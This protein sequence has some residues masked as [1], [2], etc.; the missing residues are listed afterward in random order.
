MGSA[1]SCGLRTVLRVNTAESAPLHAHAALASVSLHTDTRAGCSLSWRFQ[2]VWGSSQSCSCRPVPGAL[3]G[4]GL[5]ARSTN[6]SPHRDTEG[7]RDS[8]AA[9]CHSCALG[10]C[11]TR[12]LRP[13]ALPELHSEVLIRQRSVLHAIPSGCAAERVQSG[14]T[15]QVRSEHEVGGSTT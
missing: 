13:T 9:S 15:C 10:M 2:G 8:P 14:R 7:R 6:L 11:V 3:P 1:L 5:F 4:V 12:R